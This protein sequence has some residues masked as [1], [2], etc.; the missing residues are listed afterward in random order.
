ME[1]TLF[2]GSDKNRLQIVRNFIFAGNLK[3]TM[4]F[5]NEVPSVLYESLRYAG[6]Y[7]SGFT[8]IDNYLEF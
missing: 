4:N 7:R 5:P 1:I 6:L 3:V 8:T 2:V